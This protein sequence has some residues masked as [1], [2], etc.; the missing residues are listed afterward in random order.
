M[1]MSKKDMDLLR[2]FYAANQSIVLGVGKIQSGLWI[3][4]LNL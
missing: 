1:A 4:K 3:P 2:S